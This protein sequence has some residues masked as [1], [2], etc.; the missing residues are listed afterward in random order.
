MILH[1]AEAGT[2]PAVALL[3]GLFGAGGNFG[4]VQ[5]RLA[6][7]FRVIALDLRNHGASPHDADVSYA[8]MAGDVLQTLGALG[9]LPAAAD[10]LYIH[11]I[12]LLPERRG[13]GA[14]GRALGTLTRVR[15]KV[16]PAAAA[17]PAAVTAGK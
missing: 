11:D 14:A 10:T 8:A 12:A 9:A 2:G 16:A 7:Q 17:A 3:H 1:H 15:D 4:A 5:R 6:E 13:G